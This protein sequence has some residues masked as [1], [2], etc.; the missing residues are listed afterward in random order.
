MV[1]SIE[2]EISKLDSP[3]AALVNNQLEELETFAQENKYENFVLRDDSKLAFMFANGSIVCSPRDIVEEMSVMQ[4][5]S[6]NTN[7]QDVCESALRKIANAIKAKYRNA[8]AW[9]DV[10][11]IVRL[12]GPSAIKYAAVSKLHAGLPEMARKESI[13][14]IPPTPPTPP[15][16]STSSTSSAFVFPAPP[17]PPPFAPPPPPLPLEFA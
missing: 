16:F 2:K 8:L 9:G 15:T 14:I 10:W 1:F 13:P 12:Y 17:P 11:R 6:S 3:V 7:Y 5:L 4:Y